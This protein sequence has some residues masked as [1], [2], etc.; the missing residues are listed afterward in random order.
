VAAE[1]GTAC[2]FKRPIFCS[3]KSRLNRENLSK[4]LNYNPP[5]AIL[6]FTLKI[7]NKDSQMMLAIMNESSRSSRLNTKI[8]DRIY[9]ITIHETFGK[10]H[11]APNNALLPE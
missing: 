7:R 1:D 4:T 5:I 6:A 2:P 3:R 11:E 10:N 9:E 8:L